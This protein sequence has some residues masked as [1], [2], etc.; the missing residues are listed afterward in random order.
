M[1]PPSVGLAVF[2]LLAAALIAG[3][4]PAVRASRVSPLESLRAE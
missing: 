1:D 3:G 4:I 2:V